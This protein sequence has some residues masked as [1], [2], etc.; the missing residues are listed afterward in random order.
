MTLFK[1]SR[2]KN[3]TTAFYGKRISLDAALLET[4]KLVDYYEALKNGRPLPQ[5]PSEALGYL[6]RCNAI[7]NMH[8]TTNNL[9]LKGIGFKNWT[10]SQDQVVYTWLFAHKLDDNRCGIHR[11][12]LITLGGIQLRFIDFG[13]IPDDHFKS[14]LSESKSQ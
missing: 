13:G 3:T 1:I 4:E 2:S 9:N 7:T 12:P 6:L 10:L 8:I 5:K 11:K 14:S